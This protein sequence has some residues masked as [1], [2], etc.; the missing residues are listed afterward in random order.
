MLPEGGVG[1]I[2]LNL[3]IAMK[4]EAPGRRGP[5]CAR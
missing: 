3:P 5:L 2:L 1:N 4:F